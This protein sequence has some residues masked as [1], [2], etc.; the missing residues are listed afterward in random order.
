[1]SLTQ[2]LSD[3]AKAPALAFE[4][5]RDSLRFRTT[6]T[7][8]EFI[9]ALREVQDEEDEEFGTAPVESV[10]VDGDLQLREEPG[11]D[12]VVELPAPSK[13]E[14]R[15]TLSKLPCEALLYVLTA[16]YGRRW[17]HIEPEVVLEDLARSG[18]RIDPGGAN[19]ILSM[20][21]VMRC[22]TDQSGVHQKPAHFGFHACSL[23]GRPVR[24]D[25][26]FVPSAVECHIALHIL[27][28]LR[29]GKYEEDVLRYIAACC[30]NDSLWALPGILSI[31]QPY[32]YEIADSLRIPIDSMMVSEILQR[33][34]VI[35]A[36][37]TKAPDPEDGVEDFVD[38]EV[39]EV[40]Q[41]QMLVN[42]ALDYGQ[43]QKAKV[44]GKNRA[45]ILESLG[46]T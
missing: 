2:E 16:V 24:W 42:R 4:Q 3:K 34:A 21:A 18:V 7:A 36:D 46:G 13:D 44:W 33:V 38:A 19:K 40:Y 30:L 25:E 15:R 5:N 1:M 8:S 27:A 32:I 17:H 35:E 6:T 11:L 10:A 9:D 45:S 14:K 12:H 28:E 31:A 23:S 20:L 26:G 43:E 22:P 29:P 41:H 39:I 37:E